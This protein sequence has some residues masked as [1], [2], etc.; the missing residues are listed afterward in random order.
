MYQLQCGILC[1][2]NFNI[3][4]KSKMCA[5][6]KS[7]AHGCW[8]ISSRAFCLSIIICAHDKISD[9]RSGCGQTGDWIS[10]YVEGQ[11]SLRAHAQ[12]ALCSPHYICICSINRHVP[13]RMVV[14]KKI[15]VSRMQCDFELNFE[16]APIIDTK[17][18]SAYHAGNFVER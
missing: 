17:S 1:H 9:P 18:R 10:H 6:N 12:I 11:V 4:P 5:R 14:C 8:C 2:G 13:R 15:E 3:N 16:N 7:T